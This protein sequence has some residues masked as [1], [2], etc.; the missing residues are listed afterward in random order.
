VCASSSACKTG[1]CTADTD[2]VSGYY[3]AS[4]ICSKKV[5]DG[6]NCSSAN[7]C[8]N[9][10]C[11]SGIC[12]H[13]ACGQCHS[14]STGTCNLVGDLTSCGTGS[15]CIG[16]SCIVCNQGASCT[17]S[18][19]CQSAGTISCSTGAAQCVP[20]GNKAPGTACGSGP[21]CS[22]GYFTDQS[23][24]QSGSC[25][26]PTALRCTSGSCNGTQCLSCTAPPGAS[27]APT[28]ITITG[29]TTICS[30]TSRTLTVS[31]GSLGASA[32]WVWYTSPSHSGAIGT[33]TSI[34]VSPSSTTTYY[35][36]AEGSCNITSD[37]TNT[38]SVY[39]PPQ[40]AQG[41]QN[42][43]SPCNSTSWVGFTA[44]PSSGTAVSSIQW[45]VQCDGCSSPMAP[46]SSDRYYTGQTTLNLQVAPQ[47]SQHVWCVI[48]DNC[49]AQAE[50]SHAYLFVPDP[51]TC[52]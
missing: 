27:A 17:P 10:N 18:N 36:R 31:G 19:P 16:G 50:S 38:V 8:T 14:C 23:T 48:T 51:A 28:G 7:Q 47:T 30:G 3:C 6:G 34:V 2:C 32:S 26:V 4:G 29:A 22:G 24:C 44:T 15:V 5:D 46:S 35:V 49:G 13:T 21:S 11:V 52:S 25:T 37:A 45:W 12:C 43:S 41:P 33:G 40:F 1:A 20:G 9:N 39:P 42:Y